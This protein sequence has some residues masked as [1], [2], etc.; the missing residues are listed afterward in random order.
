M[1]CKNQ[2]FG[3]SAESI[4]EGKLLSSEH[5]LH[6]SVFFII[7]GVKLQQSVI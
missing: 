1:F 6:F 4:V 3:G 5:Y 2:N 7:S